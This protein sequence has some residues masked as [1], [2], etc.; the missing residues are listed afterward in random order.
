MVYKERRMDKGSAAVLCRCL[1]SFVYLIVEVTGFL[2]YSGACYHS[3]LLV[4]GDKSIEWDKGSTAT[5]SLCLCSF[6]HLKV[7]V[8][9]F[10]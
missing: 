3:F 10:S 7:E 2:N 1:C 9:G 4:Y 5:L 6:V 8:K